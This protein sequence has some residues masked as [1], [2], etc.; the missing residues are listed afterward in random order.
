MSERARKLVA[1]DTNQDQSFQ[2]RARKLA[3]ENFDINDEDDSEWPHNLR[4]SRANV[5]HLEKVSSSLRQ[6][7]KRK[8]GD[9]MKDLDVKML[10]WRLL[11][12][13]TQQAAVHLGVDYIENLR[14]TKNQP[15][16]SLRQ[17]F[18]VTERSITYQTE[19]TGL[20]TIDWEQH[21]VWEVSVLASESVG[22]QD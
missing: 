22:Q 10:I 17:E 18:Q 9:I 15:K 12:I 4:T 6:Q 20:T 16:K 8:P 13:V 19:N 1:V 14:S 11:M 7:L 2:E 3:A 5:P 21:P